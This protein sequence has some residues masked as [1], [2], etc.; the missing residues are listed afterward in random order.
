MAT[1]RAGTRT[2]VWM[3]GGQGYLCGVTAFAEAWPRRLVWAR[4]ALD[5]CQ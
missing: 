2:R 3:C 5:G 4:G 1:S